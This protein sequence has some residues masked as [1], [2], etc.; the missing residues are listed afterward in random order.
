MGETGVAPGRWGRWGADDERGALNFIDATK[1]ARA[2]R[3]VR[4]GR[5][6][7]LAIPIRR[8]GPMAGADVRNAPL[9]LMRLDGGDFSDGDPTQVGT[10]DDYVMM[11]THS[12]THIDALCHV[13]RGDRLYNGFS[14]REV[15]STGAWKLGIEKV[16]AIVTRGVLADVAG[17]HGLE[18]LPPGFV[19]TERHIVDALAAHDVTLERGDALLVRT[20]WL[21]AFKALGPR[22]N[23][24][25]P[26]IGLAA[27]RW[28]ADAE[29]SVIGADTPS[30]EVVPSEDGSTVPVHV[31]LVHE[32][33]VF[34]LEL[35]QL[36]DLARSGAHEF[37]FVAAPLPILGGVGGPVTP[38]AI[39]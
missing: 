33:G 31:V 9:H 23:R 7:P 10:A 4:D 36:D 19:I 8:N 38:V 25:R 39:V 32:N 16:G 15:R 13:W 6:Y 11:A 35:A 37:L 26:G 20:G 18:H 1:I 22:F 21:G 17:H 34:L 3:L 29:V 24:E 30:V 14:T 5:A 2:S 27:A 28:L 12:S